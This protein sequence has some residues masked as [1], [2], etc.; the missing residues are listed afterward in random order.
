MMND[1]NREVLRLVPVRAAPFFAAGML[2]CSCGGM[3]SVVISVVAAVLAAVV[4]CVYRKGF[5]ITA[6]LCIGMMLM[7]GHITFVVRPVLEQSGMTQQLTCTISRKYDHGSYAAYTC[8]TRIEGRRTYISLYYSDDLDV[9][10]RLTAM[11]ELS[12]IATNRSSPVRQVLLRGTI[13]ELLD[14]ETP[15]F[16]ISRSVGEFRQ[17]LTDRVLSY[18]DGK[19]GE[20]AR[21]LLF[22]DT[23]GFSLELSH[24]AKIGG[25]LHFTAVS[26]SH[27]VIIMSVILGMFGGRLRTRAIISAVCIPLAVLFFGLE[28]TVVRS[29][30]MLFLCNCGALFSRKA[31]SINS[32]CVSVIIMTATA[33]YV[34][35]D[36]GFQMSVC[37]VYGVAVVAP[38]CCD[39]FR[40]NI[41]HPHWL[42]PLI[43]ALIASCCATVCIAPV[44]VAAFE[45]ISLAGVFAT[46]VLTPIFTLMLSLTVLYA[47]I[48]IPAV[49]VL[50]SLCVRLSY[51]IILL[52]GSDN[53]AWLVLD[54]D[55]AVVLAFA[56]AI[57]LTGSVIGSGRYAAKSL[58]VMAAAMAVS[59]AISVMSQNE[60]RKIVFVSNGTSGAA[61]ICMRDEAAIFLCGSGEGMEAVLADCLLNNGMHHLR[62]VSAPE[63]TWTGASSLGELNTFYPIDEI[64]SE[65]CTKELERLCSDTAVTKMSITQMTVDGITISSAGSGDTECEA[66]I[67]LYTGYRMSEPEYG[68]Q[69]IPIYVSS[70][71]NYLPDGGINIYDTDFE[72]SLEN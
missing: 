34:V 19:Y 6:A 53:R 56:A 15:R 35:L 68:A 7:I 27:F 41:K 14:V 69:L 16:S 24:A 67:V 55:G 57:L 62:F 47:M 3:V 4:Y 26:G 52:F 17:S 23:S 28:P 32:L 48:G 29:G 33:P 2:V 11:I 43:N 60:R 44:S 5:V 65:N 50:V 36:T 37:G 70:R 13:E 10:D 31:N 1:N 21:G 64:A 22:G 63:L 38:V 59:C 66:D 54:H 18:S 71:Q 58:S 51:E 39:M 42:T 46:V 49:A 45:G 20:L 40:K 30:I 25:V 12:D 9:G 8:S 61:V 72:L